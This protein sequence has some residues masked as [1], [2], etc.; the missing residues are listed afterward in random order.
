MAGRPSSNLSQVLFIRSTPKMK[1]RL[2]GV[3]AK[4]RKRNPGMAISLSDVARMLLNR[5]L[6]A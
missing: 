5:A 6:V 3:L 2:A 4:E 1:K